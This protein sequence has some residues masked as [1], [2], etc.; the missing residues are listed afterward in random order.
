MS[1]HHLSL[2]LVTAISHQR[3]TQPCFHKTLVIPGTSY[4][5]YIGLPLSIHTSRSL[6]TLMLI[7]NA[8][9]KKSAV[10]S[11]VSPVLFYFLT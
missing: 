1:G 11:Y 10:T 2:L 4:S 5:E 3:W 7:S 9:F 8:G 6:A